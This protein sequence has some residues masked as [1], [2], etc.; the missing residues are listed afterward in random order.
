MD[1]VGVEKQ[2]D[3]LGRI[4]IPKEMRDRFA[5]NDKVELIVT[6]DGILINNPQYKLV[7][8]KIHLKQKPDGDTTSPSGF[9]HFTSSMNILK[10]RSIIVLRLSASYGTFKYLACLEIYFVGQK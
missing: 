7:K 10:M 8:S 4:C 5:L 3:N 9:Y 2:I 1:F 6:Q